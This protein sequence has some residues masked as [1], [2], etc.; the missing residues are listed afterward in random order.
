MSVNKIICF[1]NKIGTFVNI[2]LNISDIQPYFMALYVNKHTIR[3]FGS[4]HGIMLTAPLN[5]MDC[6]I[7]D[8]IKVEVTDDKIMIIK[9]V[10]K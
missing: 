8:K 7:G 3:I 6:N 5:I 9:K 10:K 1:V 4:S 2:K